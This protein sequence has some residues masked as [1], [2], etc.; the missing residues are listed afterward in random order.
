[1]YHAE[2]ATTHPGRPPSRLRC[3]PR[4]AGPSRRL[5]P[6]AAGILLGMVCVPDSLGSEVAAVATVETFQGALLETM[7]E[8]VALGF[9]GRRDRLAPTVRRTFD[10]DYVSRA[11]MSD[12]WNDLDDRQRALFEER[13]ASM[14]VATLAARFDDYDGEVFQVVSS[15]RPGENRAR[16]RSEFRFPEGETVVIDYALRQLGGE[17]RI[18]NVW[19]DGVSGVRTQRDE[20]SAI[21]KAE[22]F[23]AL[24]ER[25]G[26]RIIHFEDGGT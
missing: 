11:I 20:F 9:A 18:I 22:G 16:V 2:L 25:I 4:R 10:L 5:P 15:S 3:A 19:F 8:G 7:A 6:W 21:M 12:Y 23:D 1:M 14:A 17:W 26:E 13:F 24:L